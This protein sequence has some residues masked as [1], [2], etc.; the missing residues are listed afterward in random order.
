MQRKM[1]RMI[2]LQ[3]GK[4]NGHRKT[5]SPNFN[6]VWLQYLISKQVYFCKRNMDWTIGALILIG[7]LNLKTF[8]WP[9]YAYTLYLFFVDSE[10]ARLHNLHCHGDKLYSSQHAPNANIWGHPKQHTYSKTL[11]QSRTRKDDLKTLQ[12]WSTR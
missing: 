9:H 8:W 3:K 6:V 10:T 5:F 4:Y 11:R 1:I 12:H 2:R 7:N